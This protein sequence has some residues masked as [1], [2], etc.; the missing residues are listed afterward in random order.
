MKRKIA[1]SANVPLGKKR[2]SKK[3]TRKPSTK[4]KL[5]KAA[6]RIRRAG[7]KKKV[8]DVVNSQLSNKPFFIERRHQYQSNSG[9]GAADFIPVFGSAGGNPAGALIPETIARAQEGDTNIGTRTYADV[10]GNG[11][12]L[13]SINISGY[14]KLNES[15]KTKAGLANGD[16]YDYCDV[17]FLVCTNKDIRQNPPDPS[18]LL[19]NRSAQFPAGKYFHN[20][21]ITTGF[22]GSLTHQTFQWNRHHLGV[23]AVY[24][25]RLYYGAAPNITRTDPVTGAVYTRTTGC[26]APGSSIKHFNFNIKHPKRLYWQNAQRDDLADSG[27]Q[28]PENFIPWIAVGYVRNGGIDAADTLLDLNYVVK[29]GIRV[30]SVEPN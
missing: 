10:V 13:T 16:G 12:E 27:D 29:T 30:D 26:T 4:S 3:R 28:R 2:R 23:L 9:I 7:F 19:V 1:F 20:T 21:P 15:W 5:A 14:V 18:K 8:L 11:V 22:D 6:K 17:Y 24:K 25:W